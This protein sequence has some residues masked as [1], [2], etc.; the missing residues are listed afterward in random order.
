M[1][2]EVSPKE[3]WKLLNYYDGL[4]YCDMVVIDNKTDW[5]MIFDY[6]EYKNLL[7]YSD[8]PPIGCITVNAINNH[9]EYYLREGKFTII[10]VRD[11]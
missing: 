10:P 5:R 2:I 11:V 1:N 6:V 4:L 7:S 9:T 8:I 3:Y